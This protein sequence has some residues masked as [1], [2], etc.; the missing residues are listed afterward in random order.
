M[1]RPPQSMFSA[2]FGAAIV[3]I[4]SGIFCEAIENVWMKSQGFSL[5]L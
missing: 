1:K 5:L 2:N 3:I 4:G